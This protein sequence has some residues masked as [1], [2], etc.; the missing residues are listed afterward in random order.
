[1]ADADRIEGLRRRVQEDPASIA[2]AQ[3]AEELRRA[4]RHKEAVT[5]CRAGLAIY[6][7]YLSARVTLGRALMALGRLDEAQRELE[8]VLSTAPENLATIR[9]LAEIHQL[10][11]AASLKGEVDAGPQGS[12]LQTTGAPTAAE[13]RPGPLDPATP[14]RSAAPARRDLD[15]LQ[16]LRNVRTITALEAWL[17]ALYVTRAE[18]RA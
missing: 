16:Y 10:R 8:L 18:R 2:F 6:P 5:V 14:A 3:L 11:Q 9:A 1:M 13:C 15:E 7:E 17:A 4:D 12:G